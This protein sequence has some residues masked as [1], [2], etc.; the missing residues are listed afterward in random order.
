M[1][2]VLKKMTI[3]QKKKMPPGVTGMTMSRLTVYT[4]WKFDQSVPQDA[5]VF[6]PP[7]D[8]QLVADFAPPQ[9]PSPLLGKP[10][11]DFTLSNL[12]GKSVPLSSL[13]G[14][15]VVL[16]FWATWCGP[17]VATLPTVIKVTS[18]LQDK[19]VVFYGIN[20]KENAD[21]IR[22]FQAGKSLAFP[23]LLDSDGKIA[24][25]YK[26]KAIPQSVLIDKDGKIQAVHVGYSPTLKGILTQQLTDMLA[27]KNLVS[28]PAAA[29]APAPASPTA[30][31][32]S[33]P[34]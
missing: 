27:G 22:K 9:P 15:I 16:D 2:G 19:G 14:H 4:N 30:S 28:A 21:A 24:D 12:D 26:A 33:S 18:S 7:D 6:H 11:P 23:V 8:A 3:E 13:R 1:N 17:C 10:A 29:S 5:F 25:L 34:R 20:L 31:M 32:P